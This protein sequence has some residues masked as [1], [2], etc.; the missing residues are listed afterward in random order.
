M[1]FRFIHN[2]DG[3]ALFDTELD[4]GIVLPLNEFLEYLLDYSLPKDIIERRYTRLDN[5]NT[6]HYLI[7]KVGEMFEQD[8]WEYGGYV[9]SLLLQ[10]ISDKQ[11]KQEKLLDLIKQQVNNRKTFNNEVTP[12]GVQVLTSLSKEGLLDILLTKGD[13]RQFIGFIIYTVLIPNEDLAIEYLKNTIKNE[14][15]SA[16]A[17]EIKQS[18]IDKIISV[19][20]NVI[21]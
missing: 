14:T 18:E 1:A 7:N 16:P 6:Q 10:I 11:I 17:T 3:I 13:I 8:D 4:K 19:I 21:K 5:G 20:S 12:L 2:K 15:T 9:E